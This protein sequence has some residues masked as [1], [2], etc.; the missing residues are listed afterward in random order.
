MELK[1]PAKGV[2]MKYFDFE[3]AD[4]V[5]SQEASENIKLNALE[6]HKLGI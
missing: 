4:L 3:K 6:I 1:V 5:G 2:G